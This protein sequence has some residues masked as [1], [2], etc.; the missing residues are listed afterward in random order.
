M[1]DDK[2]NETRAQPSGSVDVTVQ[3]EQAKA[4]DFSSIQRSSGT[5]RGPPPRVGVIGQGNRPRFSSE[6]EALLRA[7]L[8]AAAI[9]LI[10]VLG[11]GFVG[12]SWAGN[13]QWL[14]F[15]TLILGSLVGS[16]IVLRRAAVL[17]M[18]SL[19]VIEAIL[20]GGVAVQVGLM[21]YSRVLA[22][23][24]KG[25]ATSMA[26]V[27]NFFFVAFVLHILTYGIFM[28]N[29][30][31][32]AAVVMTIFAAIPYA[33]W[34]GLVWRFPEV[35]QLAA[36]NQ[37]SWPLPVTLVAALIGTWGSHIIHRTRREAFQARQI[38]Q[39]RLG[40]RIGTGGMGEVYR[41]EHLLLKRP[42]AIKL[43]KTERAGDAATLRLFEREVIATARLTHWNTI[44]IY[45]YG[46]ADDGTFYYVMELLDG[47]SLQALVARQGPLPPGRVVHLLAQAC[48]ALHEAHE[49]GLIHRDIKPAN[50]FV[51]RRGGFY[52]VAK[53]LD[54]GLVKVTAT[55]EAPGEK[56]GG[57]SGTPAYMAPEQAR[58]YE[59]VDGRTDIY[60][61][62]AVAYFLLTGQPPF[63]GKD[64]V[65]LVAAHTFR[66]VVPPSTVRPEIPAELDAV[67][68]RCLEKKPADRF[69]TAQEM[70]NALRGC[71]CAAEWDSARAEA[72]WTENGRARKQPAK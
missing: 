57:F 72:W 34:Y 54:F 31:R 16:Y 14:W 5:D 18:T 50:I 60:A 56:R 27:T 39:Y 65:E 26:S 17:R 68:L 28:P 21:M 20:F 61:L 44:D 4:P 67:V 12:N 36:L 37:A 8:K 7:R 40:E 70:G 25:D 23:A 30:W 38:L 32:R 62:G 13:F 52:D 33:I 63:T 19:R 48:D 59:A 55:D 24:L 47:D 15:R 10:V 53:L 3:I 64:V 66:K 22:L 69:S 58:H 11:I 6:T 35:A 49:T 42:C 1:T 51:A 43:I 71:P 29:S 45:D 9:D 41:A 46:H 2:P